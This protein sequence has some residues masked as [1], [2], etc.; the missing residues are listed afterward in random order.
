M[1]RRAAILLVAA[2]SVVVPG[3]GPHGLR[4]TEPPRQRMSFHNRLLLNR[5]AVSGLKSIEVL[6]LASATTAPTE[7]EHQPPAYAAALDQIARAT[8]RLDGHVL[9]TE[10]EIGY[11]IVDLP[12]ARVLEFVESPAVAAYQIAS[13]SKGE[14]YRD[15]PPLL[16]A[17][18][19]RGFEVTPVGP[20]EPSTTFSELPPLT[21]DA[22]RESGY[23]ADQDVGLDE[24]NAAHPTFDGRGVTI[25]LVED[26]V[27]AFTNT[28][29]R[30]ARTLDGREVPKIAGI[31][32]AMSPEVDDSRVV[33]ETSLQAEHSWARIGARTYILP[34]PGRY[35]FGLFVL[36][37]GGNVV[38]RFG[39]LENTRTHEVWLDT[40]GD[41]SF[42]D[43]AP[44]ADVNERFEPRV[45]KL[46]HP[47]TVDVSFVMGRGDRPGVVHIYVAKGSHQT[48]TAS[49]A[50]GN[51][52]DES[53]ASGVAPN[54]RLL[55]VRHESI[56]AYEPE[57]A[58]QGFI[59]A[60]KRP[61]VDVIGSASGFTFVPDTAAEFAGLFFQRLV[62]VY[63]KPILM[64]AGNQF[65]RLGTALDFSVTLSVGG[66]L[67]PR[68]FAALSG[69]RALDAL[70]VHPAS[71]AGPSIDGAIKPDFLAPMERLAADLP[72]KRSVEAIPRN[73][74]A[75][76][77]PPGYA[78][79][80]CTSASAPYAAGVAALLISA[81]KQ[82]HLPYSAESPARAM[83]VSARF[84]PRFGAHEQGNGVLD[85]Q[86]AWH[87]LTQTTSATPTIVGSTLVAHPL[88]QYAARGP[89][90]VGILEFEGWM[91]GMTG[92]REIRFLR[93]SGPAHPATYRLAWTGNDGTFTAGPDVTLP[94]GRTIPVPIAIAPA[95]SGAHSALLDLRDPATGAVVF[96]TQATVVAAEPTDAGTRAVRI[97]GRVG[98][99]RS[100]HHYI[101]VPPGSRALA[102]DLEVFRGVVRPTILRSSGLFPEYYLH[103]H[104]MNVHAT[105]PGRHFVVIPDPEPGTWT[106]SVENSSA[107]FRTPDDVVPADL[108]DA[109]YAITVGLLGTRLRPA[110]HGSPANAR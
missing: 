86:A 59:E 32:N 78:I 53:L 80:C 23:T 27:P 84:L 66:S 17:T 58:L 36:P 98:L 93:Q 89:A 28:V 105:G 11:T 91:P 92:T 33:L 5:A 55:L 49:V 1:T 97:T 57:D 85:I 15:S 100:R 87:A 103:V 68:T 74:P 34:R 18:M 54:A 81:A 96:R 94:L 16:N 101:S 14:W 60:A 77:L 109:D 104:P 88:A 29:F 110:T 95:T 61:D 31:V 71:A 63:K 52:T 47:R 72:W 39:V 38:H 64:S 69:G 10:R 44:L 24:W 30:A 35:R 65:L 70:M 83:Q 50:A 3:I 22:S 40:N 45:L 51:R 102:I 106:I 107:W 8:E 9:R 41:A 75:S 90:G 6:V 79:S 43:E 46:R 19:Y 37:A 7:G 67:G 26:A 73:T 56:A 2:V 13:L 25:A 42:Q 48:M 20:A 12:T 108:Q 99:M 21:V 82:S 76:R 4:A 62:D